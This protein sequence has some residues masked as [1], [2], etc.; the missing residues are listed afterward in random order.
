MKVFRP[1]A[2][3]DCTFEEADADVKGCR[4]TGLR[5][6][7]LARTKRSG[8]CSGARLRGGGLSGKDN[9]HRGER[10]AWRP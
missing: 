7:I 5:E 4:R 9:N 6:K 3:P 10:G 8:V 2:S 1:L